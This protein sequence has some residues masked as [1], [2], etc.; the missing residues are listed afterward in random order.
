VQVVNALVTL[1]RIAATYEDFAMMQKVGSALEASVA[2]DPKSHEKCCLTATSN[3]VEPSAADRIAEIF[4]EKRHDAAWVR[5]V[6]GVLR[7][8]GQTTM[9]RLFVALDQ[10]QSAPNRLALMRLITRVGA[11]ALP[12]ARMRLE[13]KEWY[14]VRNACKLLGELNDPELLQ[15]MPAVFHHADQR[16][17]KVALHAVIEC[18]LPG[19]AAVIANALLLLSGELVEHALCELVHQAN[20][21]SLPGLETFFNFAAERNDQVLPQ[22]INVIAAIPQDRAGD[23]LARIANNQEITIP[24]REAARKALS[25][26]ATQRV[27]KFMERPSQQAA[28]TESKELKIDSVEQLMRHLSRA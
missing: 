1:A 5:T 16:V 2:Q 11:P 20:S 9:E 12:A 25:V 17:Q 8:A 3:L 10:E 27:D 14:V 13:S 24:L 6:G 15:Y 21:E 18:Q 26:R 28:K 22:V 4:L 19:R 23:L 7:W